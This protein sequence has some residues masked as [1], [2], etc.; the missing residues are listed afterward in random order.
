MDSMAQMLASVVLTAVALADI[1]TAAPVP[2]PLCMVIQNHAAVHR[3][4]LSHAIQIVTDVYRPLGI[5]VVWIEG[6][7][8]S[9]RMTTVHLSI[10]PR[11]AGHQGAR[12]IV[13]VEAPTMPASGVHVAHVLYEPVGTD[14][15]T[16]RALAY[17]ISHLIAGVLRSYEPGIRPTIVTG[18]RQIA[19]RIAN[20]T[21]IL[22]PEEVQAILA[23][24]AAHK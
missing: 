24:I 17:V 7:I 18:D 13:G 16:G 5:G 10:L 12:R 2:I 1:P 14:D 21:A 19:H 22:T 4:V 11:N 8:Q 23:G 20:G 9:P 6:P 3:E 15:E